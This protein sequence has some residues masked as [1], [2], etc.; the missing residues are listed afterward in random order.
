[1]LYYYFSIHRPVSIGTY[2]RKFRW[3]NNFD[4]R[5]YIPCIDHEAWGVLEYENPLTEKEMHSYELVKADLEWVTC[6]RDLYQPEHTYDDN[7]MDVL[8]PVDWV[9]D[10]IDYDS[11]EEFENEYTA[12]DTEGLYFQAVEDNVIYGRVF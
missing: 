12:D 5:I 3:F 11:Y 10:N 7:L 8:V 6:Y 4:K 1:M 2:P 9:K